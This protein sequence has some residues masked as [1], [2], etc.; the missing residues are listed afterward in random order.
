MSGTAASAMIGAL[1]LGGPIVWVAFNDLRQLPFLVELSRATRRVINQNFLI[2]LGFVVGGMARGS[3]NLI[4][5]IVAAVFHVSGSLLV[6]FNSFRLLRQ[7]EELEPH[8]A[9]SVPALTPA[10]AESWSIPG[11]AH[12]AST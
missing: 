6:V 4:T 10:S 3:L 2:G 9:H 8:D 7:G 12:P 1:I 5:P 11:C